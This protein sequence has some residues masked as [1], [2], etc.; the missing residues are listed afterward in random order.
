MSKLR[1]RQTA[2]RQLL[3]VTNFSRIKT[4]CYQQASIG[5]FGPFT[6]GSGAT[7]TGACAS[8]SA[9]QKSKR[10]E[11]ETFCAPPKSLAILCCAGCTWLMRSTNCTTE[12]YSVNA[13]PICFVPAARVRRR[14]LERSHWLPVTAS[15]TC[16]YKTSRTKRYLR[17]CICRKKPQPAGSRSIAT[18]FATICRR[19]RYSKRFCVMKFFT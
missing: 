18:S 1:S 13:V 19:R 5:Y 9:S 4:S 16:A 7:P 14:A 6:G 10:V 11:D 15:T 3:S 2:H 12:I 17:F 8:S